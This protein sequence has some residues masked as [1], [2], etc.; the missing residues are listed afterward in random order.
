M[1]ERDHSE[2]NEEPAASATDHQNLNVHPNG[3]DIPLEEEII[4]VGS[5]DESEE[6][7][8]E[9]DIDLE[10]PLME[11]L[12]VAEDSLNVDN[13]EDTIDRVA[14]SPEFAREV[15]GTLVSKGQLLFLGKYVLNPENPPDFP[16]LLAALGVRLPLSVVGDPKFSEND[17]KM[18]LQVAIRYVLTHRQRLPE[19]RSL[20]SVV[21]A[22]KK[23]NNIMVITG[24][25]ISTSLGIPD[26]RSDDGLYARLRHLGL[27]DPQEVFDIRLFKE[28]PSI[29]YSVA[30]QLLPQE[31]LHSGTPTHKFIKLLNDH[32]KLLRNYTQNID[33]LERFVG[34]PDEKVVQC[35]GSIGSFHCV[36]C[37]YK[38]ED[39][40]S[41]FPVIEAGEIPRCQKCDERKLDHQRAAQSGSLPHKK[42]KTS[43]KVPSFN[44]DA[45]DESEE[46]D[47][48]SYGVLKPDITFF[49]ESLPDRFDH[50][51]FDEGDADKCDLVICIGTS[52]RV[53]PVSEVVKVVPRETP[54]IYIS[55]TPARGCTF[56]VC[57]F[58][59]C[60]D[61]SELLCSK[62]GW[63]LNHFMEKRSK[64][65]PETEYPGGAIEYDDGVFKL[66]DE[67][68]L[69][70][71]KAAKEAS[72][73][74]AEAASA[75]E[76]VSAEG[77]LDDLPSETVESVLGDVV[78][79]AR[80]T[81]E[82]VNEASKVEEA[83]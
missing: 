76:A 20:D 77:N 67:A 30:S 80:A 4:V 29:F 27:A 3:R 42:Q 48:T 24:A 68:E 34:I 18:A 56:E 54:Q 83:E 36:T 31:G 63:D 12:E 10:S 46:E 5:S 45:S 37:G 2:R 1:S 75:V 23:A 17:F 19:P 44:D 9:S 49:G 32:K 66:I 73:R 51:L 6:G 57:F 58:G 71:E 52:L 21:E 47:D 43:D 78:D 25:G 16:K 53:S 55:K 69:A 15:V 61:V 39:G 62:L 81:N 79:A 59:G 28:D 26:F 70:A 14:V 35:H 82:A 8:L 50:M 65:M 11:L 72:E 7:E 40:E 41:L 60:D 22:I 13:N 74:V 33:N 38:V 64:N